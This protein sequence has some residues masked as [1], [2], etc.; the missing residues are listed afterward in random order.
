ME[1]PTEEPVEEPKPIDDDVWPVEEP[2]GEP[3]PNEKSPVKILGSF[4]PNRK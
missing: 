3:M 1:E 2:V 4:T